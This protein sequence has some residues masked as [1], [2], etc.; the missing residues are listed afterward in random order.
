MWSTLARQKLQ[1]F[2]RPGEKDWLLGRLVVVRFANCLLHLPVSAGSR[3]ALE[4]D[5]VVLA[6][7]DACLLEVGGVGGDVGLDDAVRLRRLAGAPELDCVG[8]DIHRLP[9]GSVLRLP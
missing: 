4:R 2:R 5:V 7:A 8:N 6:R 9:P 3:A 1:L